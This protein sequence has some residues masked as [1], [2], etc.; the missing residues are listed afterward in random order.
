MTL[1]R[2]L[3]SSFALLSFALLALTASADA[4]APDI[5]IGLATAV[6]GPVAAIGA[7]SRLGTQAA[8]NT[9][10]ANGGI[11]GRKLALQVEDDVCE[12][13]QAVTVAN[14]LA[15]AGI[16]L[17]LGHLCSN[18][19]IAAAGV[20]ADR[21]MLMMS[22]SATSP[23][24][25]DNATGDL[26]FRACGRD[27]QQGGVAGRML[28][29]RFRNG[30]IAV[31]G[32]KSAYGA[33]LAAEAAKALR[34]S[35]VKPAYEGSVTAGE[36][37]FLALVTRLQTDKIDVVYYG[38]YH[39]ELALIIRQAR[40]RGFT[41]GF[42]TGEAMATSEFWAIARDAANGTL[43]TYAPE[44]KTRP[45]AAAAV[46]AMRDLDA[47]ADPDNF[48]FYYFAAVQALTAAIA[49]AGSDDPKAVGQALRSGSFATV[50]GDLTF[51]RKGDLAAPEYVFYEW[52]DGKYAPAS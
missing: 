11:N 35:G 38:G 23:A 32:D 36:R 7:Q 44:V 25:T 5:R 30:R 28:A 10:N 33:G 45:M 43:F 39:T 52:R 31:V 19:A 41:G 29:E 14:R 51:D 13:R 26:I 6:T 21:G 46:K 20:Y 42:V 37:D 34:A 48:A 47:A 24:L 12:P 27:D 16:K 3:V 1:R 9:I 22:A 2:S 15:A 50:V 18:T 49:K 4:Q 8:I 40:E 17:V